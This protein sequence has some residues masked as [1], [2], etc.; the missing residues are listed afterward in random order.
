MFTYYLIIVCPDLVGRWW[1]SGVILKIMNKL[2]FKQDDALKIQV[3]GNILSIS[4]NITNKTQNFVKAKLEFSFAY[5]LE[6]R[7]RS[8][9]QEILVI[10]SGVMQITI[11]SPQIEERFL[12]M[13]DL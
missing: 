8:I 6:Y 12:K 11:E 4:G 5:K 7:P 13:F 1:L 3:D 9:V 2:E 10:G